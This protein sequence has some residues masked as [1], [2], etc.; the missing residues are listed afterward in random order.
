M[1]AWVKSNE[2]RRKP[3]DPFIRDVKA[4]HNTHKFSKRVNG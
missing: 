3:L 1:K 2:N 4:C